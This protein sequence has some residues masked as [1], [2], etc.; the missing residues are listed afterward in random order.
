MQDLGALGLMSTVAV[1]SGRRHAASHA[2]RQCL[3]R[4][5]RHASSA[6][7]QAARARQPPYG[8]VDLPRETVALCDI[9]IRGYVTQRKPTRSR[10]PSR[11]ARPI[12]T[13]YRLAAHR[14]QGKIAPACPTKREMT[15]E[16]Q[17][18]FLVCHFLLSC[19]KTRSEKYAKCISCSAV[20]ARE[21]N[22]IL[23]SCFLF[24]VFCKL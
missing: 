9:P 10:G 2:C 3:C 15:K 5:L 18:S 13:G 7:V 4:L 19:Q 11:P 17:D 24:R 23:L 22:S 16:K 12:W 20:L 1:H 8:Q 21:T 14:I 6:A